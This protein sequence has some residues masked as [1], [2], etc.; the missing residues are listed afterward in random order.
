MRRLTREHQN[1]SGIRA[2]RLQKLYTQ[3]TDALYDGIKTLQQ[4][5]IYVVGVK[6]LGVGPHANRV[7]Y[8]RG[9][10]RV[11]RDKSLHHI[12]SQVECVYCYVVKVWGVSR[13]R[14]IGRS[15]RRDQDLST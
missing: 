1:T 8:T 6:R 4:L 13:K 9:T 14:V 15:Y 5:C 10:L 12:R 3:G 7:C 11:G 2:R